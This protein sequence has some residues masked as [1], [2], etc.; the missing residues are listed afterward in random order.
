MVDADWE[1]ETSFVATP[2]TEELHQRFVFHRPVSKVA[3]AR[4]II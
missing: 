4:N 1:R 2:F 3:D